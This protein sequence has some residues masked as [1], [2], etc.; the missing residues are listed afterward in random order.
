MNGKMP[1]RPLNMK[2]LWPCTL[3]LSLFSAILFCAV[4]GVGISS[5]VKRSNGAVEEG[6]DKAR[7][8]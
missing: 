5:Q 2:L 3:R 1:D 7:T 4:T 8:A 6:G